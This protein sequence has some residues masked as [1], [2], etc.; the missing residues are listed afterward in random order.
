MIDLYDREAL[1][2]DEGQALDAELEARM[3]RVAQLC[4]LTEKTRVLDV[5]CGSGVMLP[6]YERAGA[7]LSR[8]TGLDLSQGMLTHARRAYPSAEFIRGDIHNFED[9]DFRL[10]D[11]VVF[12]NCYHHLH[13][14]QV[15]LR[16]VTEELISGGGL[17]VISDP[18]GKQGALKDKKAHPHADLRDLPSKNQLAKAVE[19]QGS[20][21]TGV[22]SFTSSLLSVESAHDFY[23][24]ILRPGGRAPEKGGAGVQ[25]Q[26]RGD[27]KYK[28]RDR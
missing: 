6:F 2:L 4:K 8:V 5:G 22:H 1:R 27:S 20:G 13:D 3:E 9:P 18:R 23:C 28:M 19:K 24:A 16:H 25:E 15:A 14:Q 11:R 10:F 17:V 21:T 12:N 7:S 26:A